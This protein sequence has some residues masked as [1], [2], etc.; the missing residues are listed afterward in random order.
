V[1]TE[2]AALMHGDPTLSAV[3]QSTDAI[4]IT[5]VGGFSAAEANTRI[6]FAGTSGR[7]S[8]DRS[9]DPATRGDAA[10]GRRLADHPERASTTSAS[11]AARS[12]LQPG[13]VDVRITD[14]DAPGV[15]I[16]ESGGGTQVTEPTD[17]VL[18]GRRRDHQQPG[19]D[20]RERHDRGDWGGLNEQQVTLAH[21][22]GRRRRDLQHR[23]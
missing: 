3:V 9:R 17:T 14:D 22:V 2:L 4:R 5:G 23:L 12:V 19:Y 18:L 1:A 7:R 20:R 15:L 10:P 11:P 16:I 21:A 8:R 6:A 13:V